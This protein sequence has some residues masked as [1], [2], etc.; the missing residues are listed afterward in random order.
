MDWTKVE[1]NI[2]MNFVGIKI[3]S[4]ERFS[5]N[6]NKF[7]KDVDNNLELISRKEKI[8]YISAFKIINYKSNNDFYV[9]KKFLTYKIMTIGAYLVIPIFRSRLFLSDEFNKYINK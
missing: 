2:I 6:E 5:L 8:N 1:P 4:S 3:I 9:D 7:I